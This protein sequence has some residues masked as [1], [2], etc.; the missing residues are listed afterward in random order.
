MLSRRPATVKADLAIDLPRPRN[1]FE[2]FRMQGFTET[3]DRLGRCSNPS[4]GHRVSKRRLRHEQGKRKS[5]GWREASPCDAASPPSIAIHPWPCL[6]DLLGMGLGLAHP[7]DIHQPPDGHRAAPLRDVRLGEILPHLA[8]TA[9]E[10]VLG[11]TVGVACGVVAGYALG[12]APRLA[13]IFEPYVMASYGVPKIALAPL[14]IIWFGIGL[15]SK[16]R[17]PP[18]WF[19]S[20]SSTTSIWA[21]AASTP[22][23]S[24]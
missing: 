19:S 14:F 2:A 23:S 21:C 16:S 18:R 9:E 5:A 15:W 11:Y 17:S 13:R 10:L 24:R 8:V 7:L 3:Y 22:S 20:S 4:S 6:V 1:V 12:R